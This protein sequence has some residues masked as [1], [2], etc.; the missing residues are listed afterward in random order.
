MRRWCRR[1]GLSQNWSDDTELG[2]ALAALAELLEAAGPGWWRWTVGDGSSETR[3]E[4]VSAEEREL[5]LI[6]AEQL[7]ELGK[8]EF[9]KP[10]CRG[11]SATRVH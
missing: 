1:R 10:V 11:S 9:L 4:D 5:A 2:Q 8:I 6:E 7:M 3:T